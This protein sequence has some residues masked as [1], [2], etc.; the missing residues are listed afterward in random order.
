[1]IETRSILAAAFPRGASPLC[2]W[3]WLAAAGLL[4]ATG[5]LGGCFTDY[6]KLADQRLQ[7]VMTLQNQHAADQR[8]VATAQ[9]TEQHLRDQIAGQTPRVATLPPE[10]LKDLFTLGDVK[11]QPSMPYAASK[12]GGPLDAVRVFVKT[13]LD[14]GT[15]A[16]V[17]GT[18]TINIYDP[19]VPGTAGA[20]GSLTV[21]PAVLKK[22][23]YASFGLNHF[24]IDVPVSRLPKD[25]AALIR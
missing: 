2:F 3:R 5:S 13:T 24:A 12:P 17:S 16:P 6:H 11:V 15:A 25:N 10:R 18:L 23:W 19:S 1:M 8:A 14:D 20:L 9:A 7:Q 22:S 21:S 4:A